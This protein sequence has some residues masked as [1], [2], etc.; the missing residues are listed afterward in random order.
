[1]LGAGRHVGIH[2]PPIYSGTTLYKP[3]RMAGCIS[4]QSPNQTILDNFLTMTGQCS[5]LNGHWLVDLT[6]QQLDTS[7]QSADETILDNVGHY[8]TLLRR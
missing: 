7:V 2:R 5:T 6:R 3:W 1:M 4:G 8:W